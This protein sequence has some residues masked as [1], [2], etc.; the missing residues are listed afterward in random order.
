[1]LEWLISVS[2][3][4]LHKTNLLEFHAEPESTLQGIYSE[5]LS[6]ELPQLKAS[7]CMDSL[8]DLWLRLLM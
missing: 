3:S 7:Q 1:M 2:K 5:H 4:L 8:K 6:Q